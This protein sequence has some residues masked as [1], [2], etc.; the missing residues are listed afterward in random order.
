MSKVWM[1]VYLDLFLKV[2]VLRCP[3]NP[4]KPDKTHQNSIKPNKTHQNPPEPTKTHQ[5]PPKPAP[6]PA[7]VLV[8][9]GLNGR[10]A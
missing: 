3:I 9:V 6:N 4:I 8:D 1:L 7:W 2:F 5:S 10:V